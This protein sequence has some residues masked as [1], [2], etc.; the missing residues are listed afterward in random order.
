VAAYAELARVSNLPTCIT[1]VL[2]GCS[3]GA[4]FGVGELQ[5][6]SVLRL[7]VV[8][9]L[10]YVAGMAL[11]GA[12]DIRVD[13]LERPARPLPSGRISLAGAYLFVVVCI[14]GA[15]A[16]AAPL[17]APTLRWTLALVS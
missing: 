16:A 14:V 15:F 2:V 17:G 5:L 9:V 11:N 3:L 13:R 1:N 8:I 6:A 12:A 10:L 4:A 7:S